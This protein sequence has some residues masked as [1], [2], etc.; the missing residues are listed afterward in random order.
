MTNSPKKINTLVFVAGKHF[1]LWDLET[2][3]LPFYTNFVIRRVNIR[4]CTYIKPGH[5][6][7]LP[8]PYKFTIGISFY[9][10]ILHNIDS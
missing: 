8:H 2:E 9:P 3:L 4:E 5:I 1:V 6:L 7:C 10:L